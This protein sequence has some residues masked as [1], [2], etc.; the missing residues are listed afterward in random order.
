MRRLGLRAQG[1]HAELVRPPGPH[2]E[3]DSIR[4]GCAHLD[5]V[6]AAGPLAHLSEDPQMVLDGEG[7]AEAG[8][9][10]LF[11]IGP[12]GRIVALDREADRS[13]EH[14]SELQSQSNLVC[15]LLLEKKKTHTQRI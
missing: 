3:L 6:E 9:E 13:E 14:T 7:I 12:R 10:A 2:H 1:E 8:R 11:D 4:F 15:R 5:E